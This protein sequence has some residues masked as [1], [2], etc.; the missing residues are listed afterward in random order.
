M[1]KQ[2]LQRYRYL[3]KQI[4]I[5]EAEKKRLIESIGTPKAPD[6]M[7]HGSGTSDPTGNIGVRWADLQMIIDKKLDEKIKLRTEIEEAIECLSDADQVL[8]LLRY[9]E[10]KTWEEVAQEMHYGLRH[11][12]KLH[13]A[14]LQK[15]ALNGTTNTKNR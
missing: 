8:I 2:T 11:I 4:E 14:I 5:R 1:D 9:I 12:H 3:E 15:M 13:S 6:G 7:P 10:G